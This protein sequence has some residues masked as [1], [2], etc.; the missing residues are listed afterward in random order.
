VAVE[1]GRGLAWDVVV[2]GVGLT[3]GLISSAAAPGFHSATI[4]TGDQAMISSKPKR[5]RN[6]AQT[7]GSPAMG[8]VASTE[9]SSWS[10]VLLG[11]KRRLLHAL[12]QKSRVVQIVKRAA[13]GASFPPRPCQRI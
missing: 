7:D 6:R 11:I 8:M 12:Y 1:L 3:K 2:E 4:L 5:V 10:G 13:F 9:G